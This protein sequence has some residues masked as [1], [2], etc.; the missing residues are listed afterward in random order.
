MWCWGWS[1][2]PAC[3]AVV[4]YLLS[5]M[6]GATYALYLI[7]KFMTGPAPE[8]KEGALRTDYIKL[9]STFR[10]IKRTNTWQT[11]QGKSRITMIKNWSPNFILYSLNF[12]IYNKE[13]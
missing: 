13:Q 7:L 9:K 8:N 10:L 3:Q 4:V 12:F 6:P 11:T 5:F 1:Q 2:G